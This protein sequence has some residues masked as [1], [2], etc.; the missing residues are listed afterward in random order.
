MRIFLFGLLVLS[1]VN[2]TFAPAESERRSEVSN[3]PVPMTTGSFRGHYVVPAPA[4]IADAATFVVSE[5][6]WTVTAGTATLHYDLPVGLVGGEISVTFSGPIA[7]NATTVR[8]TGTSG[9][10]SCTASGTVIRCSENF[11]DLGPLPI[12]QAIVEQTAAT[13]Y[14]GPVAN[15]V[16]VANI[17]SSDP[18]GTVDL[19]TSLVSD[20]DHGG[21]GGGG[22]GHG[23]GHGRH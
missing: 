5:V 12:N 4:S 17:F 23:G 6:D 18:I 9:S 13:D 1:L 14:S 16:A 19:D 7:A 21:G 8:L 10:G 20:D 22:G 15:R 2:C 3:Q 11:G